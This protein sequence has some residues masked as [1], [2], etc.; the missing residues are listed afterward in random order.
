MSIM[1]LNICK[2]TPNGLHDSL[3][4]T[5]MVNKNTYRP[6]Q[7]IAVHK[8]SR[9]CFLFS[10]SFTLRLHHAIFDITDVY[11]LKR[12]TNYFNRF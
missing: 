2:N 9:P 12:K 6:K 8:C 5:G 10:A 4:W 7:V 11:L 1:A 3:Q